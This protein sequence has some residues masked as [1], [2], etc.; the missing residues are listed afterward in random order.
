[1]ILSRRGI[2]GGLLA[3][4]SPSF[5]EWF[6]TALGPDGRKNI[7]EAKNGNDLLWRVE[8][9]YQLSIAEY[10]R[11]RSGVVTQADPLRV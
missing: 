4:S 11:R 6:D 2:V 9:L 3:Q 8:R 10:Q 7:N 1:M 5:W